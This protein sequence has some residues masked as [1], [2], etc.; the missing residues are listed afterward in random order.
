MGTITSYAVEHLAKDFGSVTAVADASFEVQQGSVH[1]VIGKNG[2]GKSVLM[3]MVSGVLAPSRGNLSIGDSP[4]DL[5]RWSPRAAQDRAVALVPQ[6][7]PDLPYLT[8]EEFLFLG[9]RRVSKGGV[10]QRG[11]IRRRVAEI[12]E[13]LHLQV[14]AT[15]PMVG[16]PIE[17]QQLLAFGKAVFLEDARVVLL[18]EIT[19]SLSGGRRDALLAQLRELRVGR[20]FTLISHRISE[21]MA[22]C[23]TVTV[24]RDG[25][26]VWTVKVA[27]TTPEDLA[28]AIVGDADTRVESSSSSS[29]ATST[30][31]LTIDKVASEPWL[32]EV[33]L[34]VNEGEVVGLAGVDGSGK[35]EL[36]EVLAG[37]RHGTGD[38]TL[39]GR[40]LNVR[41]PR[42]S[43]RGGVA[44]L[45]KK[46][47]ELGTIHG[48]SVLENTVLPVARLIAGPLGV[49]RD[50]T[51]RKTAAPVIESMQVKTPSLGV[52]I[53]TL[54]GGNRQKVMFSRLQLMRPKLYL[55][56]E[57][58]RG[59]DIATKPELLRTVRERLAAHSG[60]LM[61]SESEEELIDTC[62]RV[63]V[64]V[65]GRVVR[66]LRRGEP[67]FT[68]A[69]IYRTGQG[70]M[71]S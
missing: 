7:P 71:A 1:G 61:T 44:F 12:D 46:R 26:S 29:Y 39:D 47:E 28:A 54:S 15:D 20:S 24:M 9:D 2:A 3:N 38:I 31:I 8:V 5:H 11:L 25:R 59:V 43:T 30:P 69:D 37:L 40:P 19:A 70:V 42:T 63:L 22:A 57:P 4:V 64:F 34:T 41:S 67:D 17:V 51:L 55:L 52:D 13:R 68:V 16:L 49:V 6:E 23:D 32:D 18:D 33:T 60:V 58:T 45:P 14:R 27:D 53:D 65:K 10:L 48:M 66:E 21:I 56:N 36:L 62:D 50:A 35:D